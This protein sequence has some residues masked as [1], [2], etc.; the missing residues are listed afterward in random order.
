MAADRAI[1]RDLVVNGARGPDYIA[2]IGIAVED[3]AH[4]Q[5]FEFR[6]LRIVETLRIGL[7]HVEH[8]AG[9]R[10]AVHIE[11]AAGDDGRGAAF[12]AFGD[13]ASLG[14]FRAAFAVKGSED[15]GFGG[16]GRLAIADQID[17]HGDAHG[18]RQQNEFLAFV[19]TH[20][21]GGGE[22][23][24]GLQPFA[25]VETDVFDEG[26]NVLRQAQHD[27]AQARIGSALETAENFGGDVVFGG[28]SRFYS[29]RSLP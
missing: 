27:F 13:V 1:D 24:D 4:V 11:Y 26:V 19:G 3:A 15:G 8:G 17:Q 22:E 18:V 16:S 14:Q 2:A 6:P 5:F 23:F 9:D 12:G 21:A 20:L 25:F 7:P 10:L 29:S 28:E